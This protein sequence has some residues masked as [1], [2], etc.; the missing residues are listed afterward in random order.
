MHYEI[1]PDKS[2]LEEIGVGLYRE[3]FGRGYDR[4]QVSWKGAL[5]HQ[6]VTWR[7]IRQF[8]LLHLYA[9]QLHADR[10]Y[11]EVSAL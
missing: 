7:L 4:E 1:D 11:C 10:T 8:A 9:C 2:H 5:Q 3:R 6:V